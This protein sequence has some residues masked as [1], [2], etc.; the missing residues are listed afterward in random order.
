MNCGNI[1]VMEDLIANGSQI[2]NEK[3][4]KYTKEEL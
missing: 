3:T 1:I 4:S 2:E